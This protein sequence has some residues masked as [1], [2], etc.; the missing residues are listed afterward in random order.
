M[1]AKAPEPPAESRT[2]AGSSP[3]VPEQAKPAK[4]AQPAATEPTPPAATAGKP[5]T[6]A[7]PATKA[8]ASPTAPAAGTSGASSA[9][10]PAPRTVTAPAPREGGGGAATAFAVLALLVAVAAM[11]VAL[12]GLDLAR[13]AKS[14]VAP[15]R[16]TAPSAAAPAA[17]STPAAEPSTPAPSA[18]TPPGLIAEIVTGEVKLPAATG[19]AWVFVDV[20]KLQVGNAAGHEFYLSGCLGPLSIRVDRKDAAVPTGERPTPETCATQL[21]GVH[22]DPELVLA[23]RQGLTFCLLT[24][25]ADAADQGIPQRLAIVEVRSVAP[26]GSV[27]LAV[28]TYRVVTPSASPQA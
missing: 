9:K 2:G 13:E 10:P 21:A 26:D 17:P 4:S 25:Q 5:A 24:S 16:T 22:P 12:Y 19:C 6:P 27:T 20:D 14:A 23:A 7:A 15:V 18:A 11:A 3:S 28:S 1:T 8:A